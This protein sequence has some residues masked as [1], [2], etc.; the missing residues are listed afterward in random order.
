MA[1]M[2]KLVWAIA[3]P[4]LVVAILGALQYLPDRQDTI[5][6]NLVQRDTNNIPI[7]NIPLTDLRQ[8]WSQQNL[9]NAPALP[10]IGLSELYI[11]AIV[12]DSFPDLP[13]LLN[14]NTT[15]SS[16]STPRVQQRSNGHTQKHARFHVDTLPAVFN[17]LLKRGEAEPCDVGSPCADKS[18]CGVNKKCGYGPDY[19]GE[20]NCTS[21]CDALAMCGRYSDGGNIKCGMNLC[22][23]YY[24]WCGTSDVH[25]GNPDPNGLTPCQEGMGNCFKVPPPTCDPGA[26]SANLRTIGYY[27]ASNTRNR[28][29]NR[30]SPANID[31]EGLTHL[32]FAFA[33]IS[34]T[35]YSIVP[36][37]PGDVELYRPFTKLRSSNLETWIAIG[38]FDFSDPGPTRFTWSEIAA[39]P[40]KRAAFIKSCVDFMS[41]YGFQGVDLDWE[42]PGSPERG[43]SRADIANFVTLVKDMRAAFGTEY[44]L[45]LT[46][47]PDYWY[48]RF[49]DCKAMEPYVDFFGFMAY[50]LHG[51]WDADIKTLGSIVR[52]QTDIR[53]IYNNTLPLWFDQLDP[54]KINFGLAFYGRGY[55][56][57]NPSCNQ[58]ECPFT[59]PNLPGPCT[60]YPGV[61]SLAEIKQ[62]I[63]D[64]RLTPQLVEKSM[65][66]QITWENQWVGYDDEETAAM[67][68]KWA[69][70]YCFGGTMIWSV[71]FKS[72][73]GP[74]VP[75]VLITQNIANV[76]SR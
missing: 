69:S 54:K 36:D 58:L 12:N 35:T 3:L 13:P 39:D 61:L 51:F 75:S 47:A 31:V 15:F 52:A 6:A 66:K 43:G 33:K 8:H 44:G 24:G 63:R 9:E 19:C 28:L 56:L 46:L 5:T 42:Y 38:G 20:G 62:Y 45:S 40:T 30:I 10:I 65:I 73:G 16:N 67:K 70:S 18:C 48:L 59:G 37:N 64:K 1:P 11:Q 34:P 57:S 53:E 27:Q 71:D 22:C 49:F 25:C 72:G 14:S 26:G 2:R 23:S 7:P 68:T 41:E 32:Y 76:L 21:N 17:P 55:T 50:D 4:C 60:G 74:S 29:C